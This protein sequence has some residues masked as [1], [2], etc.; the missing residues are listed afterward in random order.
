LLFHVKHFLPGSAFFRFF[1]ETGAAGRYN[2][3]C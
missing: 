1:L 2:V 3:E